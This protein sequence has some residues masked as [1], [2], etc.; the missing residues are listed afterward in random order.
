MSALIFYKTRSEQ[1][2]NRLYSHG[3][4][5]MYPTLI[6][7]IPP[8]QIVRPKTLSLPGTFTLTNTK[9]GSSTD[10]TTALYAGGLTATK[11][12]DE[13]YE[14]IIYPGTLR[15]NLS[16]FTPGGYDLTWSDGINDVLYSEVFVMMEAFPPGYYMKLEWCHAR[17]FYIDGDQKITYTN[18]TTG[19]FNGYKN[20][21]WFDSMLVKPRYT[22]VRD[23][24]EIDGQ[25]KPRKQVRR[26]ERVFEIIAGEPIFDILS[27]IP[28]H[29]DVVLQD[30]YGNRWKVDEFFMEEPSWFSQGNL[31]SCTFRVLTETVSVAVVYARG[32]ETLA[33]GVTPGDCLDQ[34]TYD[35]KYTAESHLLMGS[36]EW[37]F[38][39][40]YDK[41]GVLTAL[42]AG[43]YVTSNVGS[44][45]RLYQFNSVGN[46]TLIDLSGAGTSIIYYE[47]TDE[48]W[49]DTGV[50]NILRKPEIT[51]YT[52]L[53]DP[54]TYYAQSIDA[55]INEIWLE[56]AG[57]ART[58]VGRYTATELNLGVEVEDTGYAYVVLTVSSLLC[59][60]IQEHKRMVVEN[61][62]VFSLTDGDLTYILTLTDGDETLVLA[63]VDITG[64]PD[65]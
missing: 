60:Q 2:H 54:V 53:T 11:K 13:G 34:A 8:F 19:N 49:Y 62:A 21:M 14:T 44:G 48:Y 64:V 52:P 46:Y 41:N 17:D 9:T 63:N 42:Q 58:F 45:R 57:G 22:F 47:N 55:F 1:M 30:T 12:S 51:G 33:C 31:G 36:F 5:Y 3:S 20:W 24:V 65:I 39:Y 32:Y 28:L 6:N 15:L 43:E 38:G 26:K 18:P 7:Y 10:I 4:Y 40:Y 25:F 29:D 35:T 61:Y 27:Y 56:D 23:G 59:G 37:S 16:D 50:G